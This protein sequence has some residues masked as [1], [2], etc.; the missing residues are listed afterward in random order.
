MSGINRIERLKNFLKSDPEDTFLNYALAMEYVAIQSFQ[1]AEQQMEWVLAN[2]PDYIPVYYQLGKLRADSG[3][4]ESA[5]MLYQTGI[6]R[7][8]ETGDL[9]TASELRMALEEI[10]D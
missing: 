7:C 4:L 8:K 2:H 10:E 9:K 5:A 6:A 1:L 3:N